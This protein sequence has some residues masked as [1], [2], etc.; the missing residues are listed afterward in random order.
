MAKGKANKAQGDGGVIGFTGSNAPG[1]VKKRAKT[2]AALAGSKT[3]S[4]NAGSK[5]KGLTGKTQKTNI[6]NNRAGYAKTG[7]QRQFLG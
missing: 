3:S 2:P 5:G 1:T 4:R 6:G 7:V